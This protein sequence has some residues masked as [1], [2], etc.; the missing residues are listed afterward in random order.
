MQDGCQ[1]LHLLFHL[2]SRYEAPHRRRQNVDARFWLSSF[3][4][5]GLCSINFTTTRIS[6][7]KTSSLEVLAHTD[8]SEYAGCFPGANPPILKSDMKEFVLV[9]GIFV[10]E[11][12]SSAPVPLQPG[13]YRTHLLAGLCHQLSAHYFWSR[14]R[15]EHMVPFAYVFIIQNVYSIFEALSC[16]YTLKAWW[17]LLRMLI[18]RRT[19]ALFFKFIDVIIK[20]LR[21]SQAAFTVTAKVATKDV[22]KR[23][24]QEIM[25]FGNSSVV[26]TIAATL[27]ILNLFSLIGGLINIIFLD[28]GALQNLVSQMILCGLMVLVNVPIYEA[29]FI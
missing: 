14:R 28:F 18:I 22:L 6:P 23:H 4:D 8:R 20:Q 7:R 12:N 21:L 2:K 17:N 29:L 1:G 26:F 9:N 13:S 16:R 15:D 25:E 5:Q 24:K 3:Y 11:Q 10:D 19:T 27:A